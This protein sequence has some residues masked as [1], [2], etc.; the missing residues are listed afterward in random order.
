MKTRI[1][2]ID[3]MKG[4]MIILMVC[5]HIKYSGSS[6]DN[7]M[8]L[9]TTLVYSFHMPIF[10]FYSGFFISTSKP[11]KERFFSLLRTIIIPY[12]LFDLIYLFSLY[13]AGK[14]GLHF[15]NKLEILNV[16]I[17]S[18][19]VF[20]DPIGAYWYLHTL[21]ICTTVIYILDIL[22]K[23]N[24][25]LSIIISG[26]VFYIISLF[27]IGFHFE[28]GLFLLLGYYFKRFEISIQSSVFSII[29]IIFIAYIALPDLYR[30]SLAGLGI[31]LLT[32]SFLKA[33]Y[34]LSSKSYLSQWFSYVGQNTLMILLIHPIFLNLFKI[35]T[36]LFR[37][38]DTT[39]ISYYLFATIF[40][41]IICLL[42]SKLTDK[43]GISQV[44]FG[45]KIYVEF[46]KGLNNI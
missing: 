28:N 36:P 14:M 25:Y 11:I 15:Q 7:E 23:E 41:I 13:Y 45:R 42:I 5:F 40:V 27:I 9:I 29:P 21:I 46:E 26:T 6:V 19:K 31:T 37:K 39:G 20:L 2:D 12:I 10:L 33:I 4:I 43:L 8:K 35:T 38:I 24:K 34:N 16:S 1:R 22:C 3:F 18:S 30:G 17:I 32:I 44:L